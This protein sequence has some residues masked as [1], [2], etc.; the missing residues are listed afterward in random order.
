MNLAGRGS[1]L[2]ITIRIAV[3]RLVGLWL[4][5]HVGQPGGLRIG[6][7]RAP[8]T[9]HGAFVREASQRPLSL[10]GPVLRE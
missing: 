7:L 2:N 3:V 10:M 5:G 6:S 9:D 1:P 8:G 4:E